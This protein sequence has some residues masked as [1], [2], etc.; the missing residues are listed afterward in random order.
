[1]T[2]VDDRLADARRV[3]DAV[4]Y[5]GYV[6][7]PY[8]ASAAK[9]QVRWQWGVV[10]PPA[11]AA[12]D[13]SERRAL[14]T[15]CMVE[16]GDD[17]EIDVSVRFLHVQSRRIE[18]LT[19]AGF[20]AVAS[21]T[22]ADG[23][24]L[25]AFDEAVE[26]ELALD[27][28]VIDSTVEFPI[29]VAPFAA[30][31]AIGPP[32]SEA[33]YGGGGGR[34]IRERRAL[35]GVVRARAEGLPGPYPLAK[36]RVDVGNL[37]GWGG[38]ERDDALRSSLVAVHVLLRVRNGRFLSRVDPPEFAS[39]VTASCESDG[40]WPV[41]LGDGTQDDTMLAAPIILYDHP[42]IAPESPG[43]LC[44]SLE[45]DEI[46]ALRVM[47]L[48]D[49]EKAEARSTDARAAAIIDRCDSMPAEV[50]DRLHGAVRSLRN[51]TDGAAPDLDPRATGDVPWWDPGADASVHPTE[52]TVWIRGVE[53]G[54]GSRLRLHP[55]A[56]GDAQDLFVE[57]M[58]ANVEG[59]F[60]DVD[61]ETHVAVLLEDDPATELHQ[62]YGRYMYFRPDEVEPVAAMEH[63][64]P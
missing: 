47:T 55:R 5:E 41:L 15:E 40:L 62:W 27:P 16:G 30:V 45:I 35:E 46:L 13:P 39:A 6:L 24:L 14:V 25:T 18:A 1:V 42:A 59:V 50:F 56:G 12:I 49:E 26:V 52:D 60:L 43:D 7:Y 21:I 29:E 4:L 10:V 57:G 53:V 23:A 64:L 33:G 20:E 22:T 3:A 11:Y 32:A 61:G 44:D 2:Q 8:R 36:L 28:V 37:T 9:N 34:V 51:A 17:T 58:I 38:R 19:D 48:T 54:R 63:D 31:E